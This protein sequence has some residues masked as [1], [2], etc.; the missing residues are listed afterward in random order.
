MIGR[1]G[2]QFADQIVV[3]AGK[4]DG[5]SQ[6]RRRSS[7]PTGLVGEVTKVA[8]NVALV[9]LL[10]DET[11]AVSAL[12]IAHQRDRHRRSAAAS[13]SLTI[14]RVTKDQVVNR[15]DVLVTAGW[16]SGDLSSLYPRG[17]PVCT[18]TRSAR[19]TSTSTSRCSATRSST[20]RP[21]EAVIVLV[22]KA[23]QT[24]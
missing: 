7:T 4:N 16:R 24:P 6:A 21:L 3:G 8:S 23:E 12:D 19:P 2:R 14:D 11:S 18:V 13:G 10:T 5:I 20:S 17:I 9:T 1:P 15:G 22:R